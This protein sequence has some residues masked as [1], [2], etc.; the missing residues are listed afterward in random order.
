MIGENFRWW[1][2]DCNPGRGAISFF[3]SDTAAAAIFL[4]TA[5]LLRRTA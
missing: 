2:I 1:A 3:R 5:V 4:P